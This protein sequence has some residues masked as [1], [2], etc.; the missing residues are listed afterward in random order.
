M[1]GKRFWFYALTLINNV[2]KNSNALCRRKGRSH[3]RCES[4]RTSTFNARTGALRAKHRTVFWF[5]TSLLLTTLFPPTLP[6]LPIHYPIL[7]KMC[8]WETYQYWAWVMVPQGCQTSPSSLGSNAPKSDMK[9]S[10]GIALG[11]RINHWWRPAPPNSLSQPL[12]PGLAP[13]FLP[14]CT[15]CFTWPHRIRV[16]I[17]S[18]EKC[19]ANPQEVVV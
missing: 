3:R 15:S 4:A 16:N 8:N 12:C 10:T 19:C 18:A 14:W 11:F 2:F 9:T 5:S 13:W 1:G 7:L 6:L 17:T